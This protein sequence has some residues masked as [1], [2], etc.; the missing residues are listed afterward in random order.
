MTAGLGAAVPPEP[1]ISSLEARKQHED[2]VY[3]AGVNFTPNLMHGDCLQTEKLIGLNQ[4]KEILFTIKHG[5]I[6]IRI[7]LLGLSR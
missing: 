2:K 3:M 5:Q 6:P 7:P 1:F 4:D